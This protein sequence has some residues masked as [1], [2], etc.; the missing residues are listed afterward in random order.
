MQTHHTLYIS[1]LCSGMD[2]STKKI[3]LRI[4]SASEYITSTWIHVYLPIHTI[5][6]ALCPICLPAHSPMHTLTLC[7]LHVY[8]A[9]NIRLPPPSSTGPA[10]KMKQLVFIVLELT[11]RYTVGILSDSLYRRQLRSWLTTD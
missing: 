5:V 6:F 10:T 1:E 2:G 7:L 11:A 8:T 9:N 3:T 4:S